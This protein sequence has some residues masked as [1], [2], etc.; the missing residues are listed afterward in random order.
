MLFDICRA[1]VM[2][3]FEGFH[4]F[5]GT[6]LGNDKFLGPQEEVGNWPA[7]APQGR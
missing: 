7:F 5:E 1:A 6:E 2:S 4:L 3:G